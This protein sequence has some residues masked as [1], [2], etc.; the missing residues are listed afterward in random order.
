MQGLGL[1]PVGGRCPGL[2]Y[3]DFGAVGETT[4][5]LR[6]CYESLLAGIDALAAEGL[7]D[8][9][10]VQEMLEEAQR[11]VE[12]DAELNVEFDPRRRSPKL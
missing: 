1:K 8:E 11:A 9:S 2:S 7:V 5:E 12:L 4:K 10:G 3:H 6:V